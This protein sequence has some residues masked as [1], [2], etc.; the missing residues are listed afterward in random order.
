VRVLCV[1]YRPDWLELLRGMLDR[2]GYEVV[3]ATSGYE[4][5]D[6]FKSQE[7][8]G[9]LLDYSLPDSDSLAIRAEMKHV[10][11]QIPV[12]LFAG[13]GKSTSMLLRFFDAYMHH[14]DS[15]ESVL[16]RMRR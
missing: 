12:L 6:A 2:A 3:C 14:P 16:A 15:P 8:G 13:M 10:K 9:V 5:L 11:P 4:A 1:A 7:F